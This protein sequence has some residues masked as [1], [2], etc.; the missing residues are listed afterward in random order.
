VL[1]ETEIPPHQMLPTHVNRNPRLFEE[2]IA[3][4]KAGG[5]VDFTTS[6]IPAYLA[7]GEL[8]CGVALRRMLDAGVDPGHIT[9][10]SDGQG[11]LPDFDAQGRL[12][13]LFVGRVTS[14]FAAV[15]DAVQQENIPLE[16]A[17]RVITSNPA[18]I[19]KLKAK[20]QLA[21]GCD[22][23]LVLLDPQ[24]L[25]IHTVVAM[26]RVL[27]KARKAVAKGTFE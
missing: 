15:R 1:A 23:D 27:M 22:G 5:F 25:G 6:T 7:D 26:G 3:Y 8:P 11:S 17:L 9:F 24:D 12:R 10:T 13:G 19:L 21:P 16:T 18:R 2:G 14:L 4:A 20:G